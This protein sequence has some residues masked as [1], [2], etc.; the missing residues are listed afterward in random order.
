[1]L[2]PI[3]LPPCL[4]LPQA[5]RILSLKHVQF[6]PNPYAGLQHL[7]LNHCDINKLNSWVPGPPPN[8]WLPLQSSS[9]T[10]LL[11]V[12]G[13]VRLGCGS[14]KPESHF[15]PSCPSLCQSLYWEPPFTSHLSS[16]GYLSLT[17]VGWMMISQKIHPRGTCQCDLIWET[18]LCT[19]D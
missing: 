3:L 14:S 13:L 4:I 2:F 16:L 10:L 12:H 5:L 15:M 8:P 9:T 17:V 6:V 11:T 19:C 18:G 7:Y 1:M